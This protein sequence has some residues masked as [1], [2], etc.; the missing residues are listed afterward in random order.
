MSNTIP[1][2]SRFPQ[3]VLLAQHRI[4]RIILDSLAE[5]NNVEVQRNVE[6]KS[7]VYNHDMAGKQYSY[8][9]VVEI[10]QVKAKRALKQDAA[11]NGEKVVEAHGERHRGQ[12]NG[13][14]EKP[15]TQEVIR[16]KYLVGCDG[17]H[18]WTRRQLGFQMEG[19]Q[20]DYI[21]GVLGKSALTICQLDRQSDVEN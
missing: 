5:Y 19:E 21:W 13:Q 3:G 4:E 16:A 7:L 20:S 14:A 9:I 10:A 17:A 11:S 2:M 8:P 6:P 1:G 18:S 12:L 15:I